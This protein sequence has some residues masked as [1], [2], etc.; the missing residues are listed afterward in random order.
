M[1][2]PI[3]RII[4]KTKGRN[5]YPHQAISYIKVSGFAS[6]GRFTRLESQLRTL[7]G[8]SGTDSHPWEKSH[9]DTQQ[10]QSK[11]LISTTVELRSPASGW[12]LASAEISGLRLQ[13]SEAVHS[14]TKPVAEA[15]LNLGAHLQLNSVH[16]GVFAH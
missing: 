13:N 16:A 2:N 5:T 8:L 14:G 9:H 3:A 15:C 4:L 12:S 6:N 1:R 7:T 11:A 10:S